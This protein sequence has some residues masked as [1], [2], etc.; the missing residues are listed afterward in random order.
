MPPFD[1]SHTAATQLVAEPATTVA[2][3]ALR[4]VYANFLGL[5]VHFG[6]QV[7]FVPLYLIAW[8][9]GGYGDWLL[10]T[11]TA[12]YFCLVDIGVQTFFVNSMVAEWSANNRKEFHVLFH[13]ALAFYTVLVA[14]VSLLS[15]LTAYIPWNRVFHL[16]ATTDSS[17]AA[18][19]ILAGLATLLSVP[20]WLIFGVYRCFGEY[21]RSVNM[22]NATLVAHIVL[23]TIALVLK[24]RPIIVASLM[25]LPSVFNIAWAI[26]D[27][28]R[29]HPE[30]S[31]GVR[32]ASIK[33]LRKSFSGSAFFVLIPLSQALW[34]Q[35]VL[36][37]IS[38]V[39][40]ST[41]LVCFSVTRTVFMFVRQLLNQITK[42]VSPEV[43]VLFAHRDIPKLLRL[44][45]YLNEVSVGVSAA[46]AAYLTLM[47]PV[48]I[49]L[50]TSG[51]VQADPAITGLF[52]VYTVFAG[53][54]VGAYIIPL[55]VNHHR[56]V[57]VAFFLSAASSVVLSLALVAKIGVAGAVVAIIISDLWVV[58][59]V[60]NANSALLQK[61]LARGLFSA[62]A[63]GA[64]I[65]A[66]V[67]LSTWSIKT[68][69]PG[70]SLVKLVVSALLATA[71]SLSIARLRLSTSDRD[72]VFRTATGSLARIQRF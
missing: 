44:H 17:A 39:L 45:S 35:G 38:F 55:S 48:I 49:D 5:A 71:V 1:R 68:A 7:L 20:T 65:F 61:S 18:V 12:A 34:L 27:L 42:A 13:S 62:V 11:S 64:A 37:T 26:Q 16:S 66:A 63:L 15:L 50:W 43:T 3:R 53:L 72:W 31:I 19:V 25:L 8:G 6:Q 21:A 47:C 23:T 29:R 70:H 22:A 54:W 14:A 36:L 69:L 57:S 30:V 59:C 4:G 2:R 28:R 56:A 67:W 58:I 41:A 52:A 32:Y 10:L 33:V 60:S 51:R 24:A 40:G 46:I 9:T